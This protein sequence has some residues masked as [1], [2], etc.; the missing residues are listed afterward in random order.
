MN[1]PKLLIIAGSDSCGGAG[2]QADIKTATAL[3]VYSASV[4]TSLTAQNTRKVFAIHNLPI[5][6]LKQ[7]LEVVL[8]DIQFDAIKIGMLSNIQV[9]DV[10]TAILKNKFKKIPIVLDPVMVATSGDVLLEKSAI[11]SLKKNLINKAK[12]VTPNIDEAEILSQMTI[13]NLSDMKESA[14]IIK[15][16]GC[17]A[18]LI[19][20]G[21]LNFADGKVHS[22]LLDEEDDYYLIS[23]KKI[24]NKDIHG[25]GCTLAS[26][27]ASNLAKK[28]DLINAVRKA[29]DYVYR[30]V[31]S[32][33][34]AGKGSL[35]LKHW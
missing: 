24:G 5:E 19:K 32:N 8:E 22:L 11:D 17:Q 14:T 10:I 35:V 15:N 12:I 7:Q 28:L 2:L 4:V 33:I 1:E 30:C 21:H 29:N 16:F 25:T 34:K 27:I 9:I 23:N 20:G 26:A 6:F 13:K 18:V 31:S 3:K